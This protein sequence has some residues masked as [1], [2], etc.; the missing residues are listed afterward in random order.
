[1]RPRTRA[2]L[3]VVA[4]AVA[5]FGAGC[6]GGP[7]VAVDSPTPLLSASS[8]SPAAAVSPSLDADSDATILAA[9]RAYVAA[10]E[11]VNRTGDLTYLAAV[12]TVGCAC[13]QG[14]RESA[15]YINSHHLHTD[16]TL[17][18]ANVVI[19]AR[20]HVAADTNVVIR[21]TAFRAFDAHNSIV[22]T[23]AASDTRQFVNFERNGDRWLVAIVTLL[24]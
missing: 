6:G 7:A 16:V 4:L 22:A 17:R 9:A 15:D 12:A 2:Q 8:S 18:A 11:Q 10:L 5:G 24:S 3:V 20:N 19:T 14:A 23:R 21:A 1:M 13:L